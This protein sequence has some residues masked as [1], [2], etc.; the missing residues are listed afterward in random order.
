MPKI[1]CPA[2]SDELATEAALARH[3]FDKHLPPFTLEVLGLPG[4]AKAKVGMKRCPCGKTFPV[5]EAEWFM[6]HVLSNGGLHVHVLGAALG[7]PH[8]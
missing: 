5:N 6:T 8:G 1:R 3:F 2:C 7:V 4:G